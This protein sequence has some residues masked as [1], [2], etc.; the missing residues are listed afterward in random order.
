[1][2]DK[3][4]KDYTTED[5]ASIMKDSKERELQGSILTALV[6]RDSICLNKMPTST[7]FRAGYIRSGI[8]VEFRPGFPPF[9]QDS[10]R[11]R[12]LVRISTFDRIIPFLV[13]QVDANS[14]SWISIMNPLQFLVELVPVLVELRPFFT[15]DRQDFDLRPFDQDFFVFSGRTSQ[16]YTHGFG[17]LNLG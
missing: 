11:S 16:E 1:M 8:L 10:L 12:F 4:K 13:V 6:F 3:E 9:G 5:L 2:V 15:P 14:G 7:G 17:P